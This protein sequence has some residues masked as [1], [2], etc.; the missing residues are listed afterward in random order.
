MKLRVTGSELESGSLEVS[1]PDLTH[2]KMYRTLMKQAVFQALPDKSLANKRKS[3]E[4][5]RISVIVKSATSR[6]TR[7][8]SMPHVLPYYSKKK[9]WIITDIM[10]AVVTKLNPKMVGPPC[11]SIFRPGCLPGEHCHIVSSSAEQYFE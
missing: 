9:A 3:A 4:G 6:C 11:R 8:K 2:L 1:S 7:N 5:Q 10:N